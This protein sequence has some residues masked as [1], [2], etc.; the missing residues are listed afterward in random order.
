MK[1][2]MLI[3]MMF[4]LLACEKQGP[5]EQAGEDLDEVAESVKS[6]AEK[7]GDKVDAA[8]DDVREEIEEAG[9]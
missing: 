5:M 6:E 9:E 3:P 1:L 4:L 7:A 8:A 2:L